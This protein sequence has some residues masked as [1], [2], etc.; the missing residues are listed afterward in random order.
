MNAQA[1]GAVTLG[2]LLLATPA[3]LWL[4]LAN[5][6]SPSEL[7]SRLAL[8]LSPDPYSAEMYAASELMERGRGFFAI[9]E[10]TDSE[11]GSAR[12]WLLE[13]RA[14]FERAAARAGSAEEATRAREGWAGADLELA[15]WGLRQGK[16]S[17][18]WG[19]DDEDLFRWGLAYARE[20]L[21]LTGVSP[22]L[23]AGLQDVEEE[24]D[25]ELSFWR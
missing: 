24:L 7:G 23:R 18:R 14:R 11:A 4:F 9:E 5:P 20:G 2:A 21:G 25:G 19:T 16:G 15:R 6:Q 17:G 8:G 12:R 13:A 10:P 1:R 3:T 22:E